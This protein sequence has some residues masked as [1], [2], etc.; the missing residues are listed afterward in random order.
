MAEDNSDDNNENNNET[1][2]ATA[3]KKASR[4]KA[5]SKKA[6][7]KKAVSKKASVKKTATSGKAAD[8]DKDATETTAVTEAANAAIQAQTL[9]L[10]KGLVEGLQQDNLARDK[11]MT[12]LV[13]E[14]RHG[15]GSVSQQ[16]ASRDNEQDQEMQ[17]LHDSLRNAFSNAED[18]NKTFEERNL[19]VLKTLSESLMRDHEM[20]LKEMQEQSRLQD[21]KIEDLKK[22]EEQR[23]RR[24]RWLS[25]PGIIIAIIA[26]IYMFRVVNVMEGAM[27]EMSDDM[28][29]MSGYMGEMNGEVK[30]MSSKMNGMAADTHAMQ[31]G[32]TDMVPLMRGMASDTQAMQ[33][34]VKDM[35]ALMAEMSDNTS[36]MSNDMNQL[37]ANLTN[38]GYNL[39]VMTRQVSP[40]MKGMR[41]VMPWTK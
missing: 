15:F 21:K 29:A 14:I 12:Q 28:D 19:T 4:K 27:T 38:M 2:S 40:T 5:V 35:T 3:S 16:A 9:D 41:D 22:I 8:T 13:G 17:R 11:Q 7:P 39:G 36:T 1:P 6:A 32:M 25:V 18:A 10:I 31:K 23:A 34:G 37:N 26:I 20:T 33:S 30:N 24:N